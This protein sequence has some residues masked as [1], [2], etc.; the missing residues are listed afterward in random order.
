VAKKKREQNH[1]NVTEDRSEQGIRPSGGGMVKKRF[2]HEA[3]KPGYTPGEEDTGLHEHQGEA[4]PLRLPQARVLFG[5]DRSQTAKALGA[6]CTGLGDPSL[7]PLD[8]FILA[9]SDDVSV[10]YSGPQA[11]KWAPALVDLLDSLVCI[12][13]GLIRCPKKRSPG[14]GEAKECWAKEPV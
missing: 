8:G 7:R 13:V 3:L 10:G 12:S 9:K 1:Y 2:S 5:E 14:H 4:G 6:P 11:G